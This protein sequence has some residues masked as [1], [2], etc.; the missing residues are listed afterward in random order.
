MPEEKPSYTRSQFLHASRA[1]RQGEQ[2][3]EQAEKRL[4]SEQGGLKARLTPS[5]TVVAAALVAI[6]IVAVMAGWAQGKTPTAKTSSPSSFP[7]STSINSSDA[8][9]VASST[10]AAQKVLVH[11]AGKVK[12]PGVV[13]LDADSRVEDAINAAGG[14]LANTDVSALNLARKVNDG[15]QI[16]VGVEG[17]DSSANGETGETADGGGKTSGGNRK[18][19]INQAT[20]EQLE[21]LPGVGESLAE[22]IIAYRKEQGKFQ[23]VEDLKNV[24]GIGEKKYAA[25]ADM[26]SL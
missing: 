19:S 18:I 20:K 25:L 8:S 1:A 14:V 6:V 7:S 4:R 15:E 11:V 13:R 9:P 26:I 22:R 3:L 21:K 16:L 17:A 5:P 23:S 24:S 10:V 2:L 12:K